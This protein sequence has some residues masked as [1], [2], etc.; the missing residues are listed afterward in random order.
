MHP[1]K[2]KMIGNTAKGKKRIS[3]FSLK[4]DPFECWEFENF[5]YVYREPMMEDDPNQSFAEVW[6]AQKYS[7]K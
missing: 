4:G 7:K 2:G 6:E 1:N 3:G 5:I